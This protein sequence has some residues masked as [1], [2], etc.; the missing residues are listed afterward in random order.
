MLV[1]A[2]VLLQQPDGLA[3]LSEV[4]RAYES[5]R[6]FSMT[7]EHHESNGLFPGDFSQELQWSKGRFELRVSAPP[8]APAPEAP[9]Y[10][11]DSKQVVSMVDGAG[12]AVLL[13]RD[14]RE[15]PGWEVTGGLVLSWL[16]RTGFADFIWHPPIGVEASVSC[17]GPKTW[18]KEDTEQLTLTEGEGRARQKM[19]LYVSPDHRRLI[20]FGWDRGKVHGW[21]HYRDQKERTD[22]PATL[23]DVH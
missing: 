16:E 4:R 6:G 1:L 7:I 23:G 18:Q 11:C 8:K 14:I 9:T 5:M 12:Q 17:D 13:T 15:M 20:G 19:R 10:F 22:L 2:L 21:A 3:I